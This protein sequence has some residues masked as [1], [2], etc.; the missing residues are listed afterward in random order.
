[1][2]MN[3]IRSN[4]N[5]VGYVNI[6][7]NGDSEYYIF[8]TRTQDWEMFTNRNSFKSAWLRRYA[9]SRQFVARGNHRYLTA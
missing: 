9:N 6:D 5:G 8:S 7:E 4:Q 2:N 3:I 1:M